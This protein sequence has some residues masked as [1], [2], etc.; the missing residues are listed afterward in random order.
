[1]NI[2]SNIKLKVGSIMIEINKDEAKYLR[3]HGA[4]NGVTRLMRQ[5]SKRKHYYA[6]EDKW[7][8]DL[9][10]EYRNSLP[11]TETYGEV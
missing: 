4:V 1:M 9:L 3:E 5:D 10:D 11:I 7:I 8:V 2:F 6:C